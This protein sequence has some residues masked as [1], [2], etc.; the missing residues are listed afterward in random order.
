MITES[1][2]LKPRYNFIAPAVISVLSLMFLFYIDEG[3]NDF[4]WMLSIGNW[5]IFFIFA[6]VYYS[7]QIAIQMALG[8][9]FANF[10][11]SSRIILAAVLGIGFC[12]L[13]MYFN[14][15]PGHEWF[16]K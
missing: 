5:I 3:Y 15:P 8:Y 2:A 6:I 16:K 10:S 1:I 11:S 14:A 9:L 13:I 4:R 12:F 7:M